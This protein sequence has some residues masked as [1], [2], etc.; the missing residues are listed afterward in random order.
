MLRFQNNVDNVFQRI[1]DESF[2]FMIDTLQPTECEEEENIIGFLPKCAKVFT[3]DEAVEIIRKLINCNLDNS[4]WKLNDYHYL[5][6]YEILDCYVEICNDC[7]QSNEEPIL[8]SGITEIFILDMSGISNA[9]FFDEDFLYDEQIV[10]DL[11]AA[12]KEHLAMDDKTFSVATGL[13]PH[14]DDLL[15]VK[16]SEGEFV[17]VSLQDNYLCVENGVYPCLGEE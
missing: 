6:I 16:E 3:D 12:Q 2:K 8:V 1:L 14:P 4:L 7:S 15:L 13:K 10:L 5:L 17:P 9:Y 11:T